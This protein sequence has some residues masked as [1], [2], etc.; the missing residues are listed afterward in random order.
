MLYILTFLFGCITAQKQQRAESRIMLGSA[1]LKEGD[2]PG[3]IGMLQ[4]ATKFNPKS[5]EAWEKLGLAYYAQGAS[6]RAEY[7]FKRALRISPERAETNNN[8]ALI[9][10]DQ[11][12]YDDAIQHFVVASTDLSYRNTAMV[13]SNLGRAQQL[14]QEPEAALK[15]L[16]NAV[17]RAPNLCIAR[18][19]RGLVL[20]EL[21]QNLEAL[22]DFKAVIKMCGDTATGAYYQAALILHSTDQPAA[23]SY[24]Q[25]VITEAMGSSLAIQANQS[26]QELC[27]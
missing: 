7:A 11:E 19:N 15:S 24:L 21:S 13:L 2:I 27:K 6:E 12:R 8:Y 3:A 4:E 25:T 10:L 5:A 20:K 22:E 1:Y 9:L 26:H 18:F 14:A 17:R 23:C 16:N